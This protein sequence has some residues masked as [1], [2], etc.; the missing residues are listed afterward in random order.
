MQLALKYSLITVG[1]KKKEEKKKIKYKK[2]GRK[3]AK[4]IM[5]VSKAVLL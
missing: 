3:E 4:H 5:G 2:N 1:E